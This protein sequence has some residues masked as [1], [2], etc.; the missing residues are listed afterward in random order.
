MKQS[1]VI[2]I[3]RILI[4]LPAFFRHVCEDFEDV[5]ADSWPGTASTA[6]ALGPHAEKTDVALA[7]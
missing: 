6:L 7:M 5:D 4:R 1:P 3:D 2:E